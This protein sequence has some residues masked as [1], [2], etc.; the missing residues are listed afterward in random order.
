MG[1]HDEPHGRRRYDGSIISV[2]SLFQLVIIP[3]EAFV[4][5]SPKTRIQREIPL[6][7]P[8]PT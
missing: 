8:I 1:Y 3:L 2:S 4:P 7:A 6:V 5:L